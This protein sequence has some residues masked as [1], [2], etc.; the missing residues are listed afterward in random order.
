M[1][2]DPKTWGA[3]GLLRD[4]GDRSHQ[5]A[6][7]GTYPSIHGPR[8]GSLSAVRLFSFC[9]V[10]LLSPP[11]VSRATAARSHFED[12][13]ERMRRR[14]RFQVTGYVVTSEA[15]PGYTFTQEYAFSGL[16]NGIARTP[17]LI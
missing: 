1:L 12:I 2:I 9:H 14:Y 10:Q 5:P 3:P 16:V 13:L 7:E 17:D 11:S 4:L 8:F 6:A 15:R